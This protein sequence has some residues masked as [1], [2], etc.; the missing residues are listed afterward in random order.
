MSS[1][2]SDEGDK[3][4]LGLQWNTVNVCI[5]LLSIKVELSPPPRSLP[6][7]LPHTHT[8]LHTV[9]TLVLNN[10]LECVPTLFG[11][12]HSRLLF[13]VSAPYS[14]G[15]E[16]KDMGQNKC[17]NRL[18]LRNRPLYIFSFLWFK[19]VQKCYLLP[20]QLLVSVM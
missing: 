13:P 17:S 2:K 11:H 4:G 7:S 12:Q 1:L 5:F 3:P 19:M 15:P 16:G 14:E 10:F 18:I 8:Q 9:N 6:D 20:K